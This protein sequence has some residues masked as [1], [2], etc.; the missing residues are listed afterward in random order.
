MIKLIVKTLMLM[1][2]YSYELMP[3]FNLEK[4]EIDFYECDGLNPVIK[5][6]TLEVINDINELDLFKLNLKGSTYPVEMND[7]NT[8]CDFTFPYDSFG[9][10]S[11]YPPSNET[12]IMINKRLVHYPNNLY[13]ILLHEFIHALGLHHTEENYGIMNYSVFL[14]QYGNLKSDRHLYLSFDDINGLKYLYDNT[15][16][17]S[18]TKENASLGEATPNEI[19][20]DTAPHSCKKKIIKMVRDCF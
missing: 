18:M 7:I 17:K 11:F 10:C 20:L 12:D 9:Y 3:N 16:R 5:D 6:K 19:L 2:A 8:I 15:F 13:N 4:N 14:D 1:S